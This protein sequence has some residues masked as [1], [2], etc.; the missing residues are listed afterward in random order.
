L[1]LYIVKKYTELL[2]G[3]VE[4]ESE[5]GRGSTFIITLP[6]DTVAESI[7]AAPYNIPALPDYPNR[8]F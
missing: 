2:G 7:A 3:N 6:C 1:G 4:V 8:E 5:E